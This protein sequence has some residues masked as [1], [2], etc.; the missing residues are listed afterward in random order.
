VGWTGPKVVDGK[1]TEG[2]FRSHQVPMGDMSR[3]GHVKI[4][5]QWLK[6]YR[7]QELFDKTGRLRSE[8]AEVAPQGTRRMGANPHAN[9]G[10]LL[11]D[12][13]LPDFR[14]Y[15]AKLPKPGSV[16]AEATRAEGE[17]IRG[18]VKLNPETFRV[19]SP[20]ETASNRWGAVFVRWGDVLVFAHRDMLRIL[21]A[22][23][24]SLP[25]LEAR[26]FYLTTASLSILGYDHDFD[27]PVIRLWN[28]ARR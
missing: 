20:D 24:L 15:A 22:R 12:L 26:K 10:V 2:T 11:R 25:A 28:D 4:L 23:R 19:F 8:L 27:E 7:P 16:N 1:P 5:E 17:L 14:D 21:A 13:R 9:G 3:P 18:V 6:S